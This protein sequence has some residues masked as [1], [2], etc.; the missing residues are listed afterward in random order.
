MGV[1]LAGMVLRVGI[2]VAVLAAVGLLADKSAFTTAVLSFLVAFTV[3]LPL[4][5]VTYSALQAPPQAGVRS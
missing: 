5:L 4:R 1:A 3:Y 2:V